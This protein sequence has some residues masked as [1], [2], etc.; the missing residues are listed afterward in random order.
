MGSAQEAV[1]IRFSMR[2]VASLLVLA[3]AAQ[4]GTPADRHGLEIDLQSLEADVE[5]MVAQAKG[6]H[7]LE[8]F[9][10]AE[11]RVKKDYEAYCAELEKAMENARTSMF[12]DPG[13]IN[14]GPFWLCG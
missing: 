3:G 2:L 8:E 10:T 14:Y 1:D 12:G 4:A 7:G 9:G 13:M 11:E 5:A 6:S